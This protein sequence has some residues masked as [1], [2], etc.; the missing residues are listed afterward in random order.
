MRVNG[1]Y[2]DRL[3]YFEIWLSYAYFIMKD[4]NT[5]R[6]GNGFYELKMYSSKS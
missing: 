4:I 6:I 5:Q 3:V 2:F 1:Q